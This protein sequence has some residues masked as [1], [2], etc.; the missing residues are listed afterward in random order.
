MSR[1][2]IHAIYKCVDDPK[3][4]FKQVTSTYYVNYLHCFIDR[5]M[6]VTKYIVKQ[7]LTYY[8]VPFFLLKTYDNF[9]A[10]V[11]FVFINVKQ[12]QCFTKT[13][14]LKYNILA[15]CSFVLK[16]KVIQ[17]TAAGNVCLPNCLTK[18]SSVFIKHK[19]L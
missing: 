1:K 5:S 7:N 8:F 15:R 14:V 4:S 2:N 6:H 13:K 18:I 19:Y 10:K 16:I 3:P 17:F 11:T 12:I 9:I